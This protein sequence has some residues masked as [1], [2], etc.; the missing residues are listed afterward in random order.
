MRTSVFLVEP[1][2]SRDDFCGDGSCG[3]ADLDDTRFVL[4]YEISL[5]ATAST[6]LDPSSCPGDLHVESG[7]DA[8]ALSGVAGQHARPLDESIL[9]G[10][11]K[12]GV[13]EYCVEK[14]YVNQTFYIESVCGDP[15][16]AEVAY[17][18]GKISK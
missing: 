8:E 10:R 3:V 1:W 17:F 12:F 16:G 6:P 9:P 14:A 7:N 4:N 18:Q 15:A 13:D 11:T 2:G 5:P